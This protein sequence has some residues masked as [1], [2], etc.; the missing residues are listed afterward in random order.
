MHASYVTKQQS[1]QLYTCAQ[2]FSTLVLCSFAACASPPET[3]GAAAT[4]STAGAGSAKA[5]EASVSKAPSDQSPTQLGTATD[6]QDID[7]DWSPGAVCAIRSGGLYCWGEQNDDGRLG[8]GSTTTYRGLMQ[9]GSDRDWTQIRVGSD[10]V[11]GIRA[12]RLY[13]WGENEEGQLG[14]GNTTQQNSPAQ[15]GSASDWQ[16]VTLSRG[17]TCGVRGGQAYCWG[18]N[19]Q[20]QIGNGTTEDATVPTRVG[21]ETGWSQA[22]ATGQG[23]TCGIR[24]G[25][26]YCWGVALTNMRTTPPSLTPTQVGSDADWESFSG[27]DFLALCGI[28]GGGEAHCWGSTP[29]RKQG[30]IDEHKGWTQLSP[31]FSFAC[32]IRAGDLYCALSP[33]DDMASATLMRVGNET[34]WERIAVG[35]HYIDE[36]MG[37]RNGGLYYWSADDNKP[38]AFA[39][40]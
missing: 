25:A 2:A 10:A 4:M 14:L 12:G 26:L 1:A 39:F 29:F 15:V 13:C 8:I 18:K 19:D 33:A 35:E 16:D 6:W 27:D 3:I 30:V 28:R 36:V 5:G 38:W 24:G 9:V 34:G 37:I 20:G 17:Y 11:C 32:G 23:T 7:F 31:G 40:P 21:N 22:V